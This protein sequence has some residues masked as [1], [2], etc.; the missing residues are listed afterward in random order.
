MAGKRKEG[1]VRTERDLAK[2]TEFLRGGYVLPSELT[3][4]A[5]LRDGIMARVVV[6]IADGRAVAR[7][8]TVSS[9]KTT[10][11][12]WTTL[13]GIPIRDVVATGVLACLMR[14]T[15]RKDGG[16][17]LDPL[18]PNADPEEVREIVQGSV[19]YRPDLDRFEAVSS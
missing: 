6:E 16:I 3:A 9:S 10:G 7:E 17:H 5:T 1:T 11:V 8:V 2:Y 13:S 12:G 18:G 14:A 19:G 15:T 4:T